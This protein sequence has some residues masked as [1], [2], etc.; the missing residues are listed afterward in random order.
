MALILATA[1]HLSVCIILYKKYTNSSNI[2]ALL[3]YL[4]LF[5]S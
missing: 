3:S 5:T 4:S 1:T 2:L